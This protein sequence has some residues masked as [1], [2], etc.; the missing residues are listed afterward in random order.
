[1]TPA[2]HTRMRRIVVLV[3]GGGSN[4]QAI[5][6]AHLENAAVVQVISNRAVAFAL[7]RA[8]RAGVP[9]RVLALKPVRDAGGT[10][11]D[12]ERGLEQAVRDAQPD[13][14]VLAGWM[15]ILGPNFI[16][17]FAG[18]PM[19]NLHPALPGEFD[20]THAIE[21]AFAA[22]QAGVI[23]RS[24]CMVHHVVPAVDAGPVV[25]LR[26][27]PFEP[28]DTLASFE[29]RLHAAEH[30]LMVEAVRIALRGV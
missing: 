30:Q 14:I 8:A 3:S 17:S 27:V 18:T 21:R 9:A 16:A 1:M 19:I 15:H 23:T 25:A 29:V 4:L 10:R 26:E 2:S 12:Y 11:E 20:G 7:E 13:L 28:G 5:L 24:G 22:W 6:D